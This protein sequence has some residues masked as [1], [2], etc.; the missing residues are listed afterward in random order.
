[1]ITVGLLILSLITF[2]I[3]YLFYGKYL[4]KK[5]KISYT[6]QVPSKLKIDGIDF[7]PTNKW[8]LLGHHFS[9]IAGAGPI[10]GPIIAGLAY[11]WIPCYLWI[12]LGAIL[13]GGVHDFSSLIASIRH[14]GKSIA[15]ITKIYMGKTTYKIFLAFI[16]FTLIYVVTVFIDLA[17]TSF[18]KDPVIA[19]INIEYI[20]IAILIGVLVYRYKVRL[21]IATLIGL[22]LIGLIIYFSFNYKILEYEKNVW[23]YVL[24]M[25]TFIA[26]VL[27][28]WVLL[29]PRD[30]LS[31][32]LLFSILV[33]GI[34]GITVTRPNVLYPSF[35]KLY[36]PKTGPIFPFI[37][38]TVAC[39]AISGFHSLV[40]SGT[41][42]K[43]LDNIKNARFV[44]YGGMLLEGILAIIAL[45]TLV[46]SGIEIIQTLKNPIDIFSSGIGSFFERLG[47]GF[48]YGRI[49]GSLVLSAF[50]LTTLD[51]AVRISRYILEE[52]FNIRKPGLGVRFL[53]TLACLGLPLI[54]VN[55]KFHAPDG[56]EIP[57]WKKI[58]P[59]FGATNQLLAALV[60][61]TIY[62]WVRK[63]NLSKGYFLLI[64]GIFMYV[65][66]FTGLTYTV[67]TTQKIEITTIIAILLLILAS[68]IG[69]KV[70]IQT[71]TYK[72]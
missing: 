29:Q 14:Q 22:V 39:G 11:G 68:Y 41:T 30:Y 62:I 28:V 48:E 3:A 42:S 66:T 19:Q 56:T 24:F 71:K 13:I 49:W 15:E 69:Y 37:F 5:Y 23:I 35:L 40:S 63:E 64:P 18:A 44:G 25:Y 26:S 20:F 27:P 6:E 2:L 36:D 53:T 21:F 12:I 16:W 34:L 1:M 57:V 58:W 45:L 33:I 59:L 65:V 67:L 50:I 46:M 4:E 72:F 52:F 55:L 43:Q 17:A 10:L 60:F 47:L 7:I 9:S 32:F 70:F 8:I 54:L 31:S 61:L 38:I 51:T